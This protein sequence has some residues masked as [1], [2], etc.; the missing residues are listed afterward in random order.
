[1][2]LVL[3]GF[4]GNEFLAMALLRITAIYQCFILLISKVLIACVSN[5]L[6][7]EENICM[8][9]LLIYNLLFPYLNR[10]I[11]TGMFRALLVTRKLLK[12]VLAQGQHLPGSLMRMTS[13]S[14]PQ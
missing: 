2:V 10:E 4:L 5:L 3:I 7:L 8:W 11:V 13:I 1:M 6:G 9:C 12:M 14:T